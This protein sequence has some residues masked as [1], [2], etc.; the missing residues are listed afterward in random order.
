M[1]SILKGKVVDFEK[2]VFAFY[3]MVQNQ[4]QQAVA[5]LKSGDFDSLKA[6]S[7]IEEKIDLKYDQLLK[8][9][10]YNLAQYS[11]FGSHLRKVLSYSYI[12]NELERIGD[13]GEQV[14]QIVASH[15]LSKSQTTL[16]ISFWEELLLQFAKVEKL[17]FLKS[18][19]V[20]VDFLKTISVPSHFQTLTKQLSLTMKPDSQTAVEQSL[21]FFVKFHA[22]DR[23]FARLKN[24]VEYLLLIR[25]FAQFWKYRKE[26][27]AF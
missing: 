16:L 24:I 20:L 27:F 26:S 21:S 22:I 7:A 18:T 23:S 17:F 2:A 19:T 13:Y 25:N 10:F 1:E 12:A 8:K 14:C 4:H 3:Q 5:I 9:S 11:F 15:S 6:I